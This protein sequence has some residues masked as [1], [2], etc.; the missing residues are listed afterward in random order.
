MI[1]LRITIMCI[2]LRINSYILN[3]KLIVYKIITFANI[4]PSYLGSTLM[5]YIMKND[6]K[7]I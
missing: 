6:V 2:T 5:C 7:F 4:N 1:S 3:N